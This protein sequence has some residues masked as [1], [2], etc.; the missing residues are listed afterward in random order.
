MSEDKVTINMNLD[1]DEEQIRQ[2]LRDEL[3]ATFGCE[4][5]HTCE[6]CGLVWTRNTH[7]RRAD[8]ETQCPDCGEQRRI[9]LTNI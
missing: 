4:K 6:E 1:V 5:V 8:N 2:F 3:S 9:F 7:Y